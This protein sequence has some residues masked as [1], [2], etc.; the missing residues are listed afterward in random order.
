MAKSTGHI[1]KSNNVKLEGQIQLDGAQI[2]AVP[3]RGKDASSAAQAC[4]VESH[5]EFAVIE[6]TCCCGTKTLLK[7]EYVGGQ[8]P[9]AQTSD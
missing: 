8:T 4:I 9:P 2:A 7:C 3:S 5:P 6:I 1:L